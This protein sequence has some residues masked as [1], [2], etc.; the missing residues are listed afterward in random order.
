MPALP[1]APG[2]IMN[3]IEVERLTASHPI[4]HKKTEHKARPVVVERV[5][6]SQNRY[7]RNIYQ[8]PPALSNPYNPPPETCSLVPIS[9]KNRTIPPSPQP[10]STL[11]HPKSPQYQ[12]P[13]GI[14][15]VFRKT[16]MM[17]CT[18]KWGTFSPNYRPFQ[19]N[20]ALFR[21]ISAYLA[22]I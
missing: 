15:P 6:L 17:E 7:R 12:L 5:A 4:A 9:T 14:N 11:K 8:T 2:Q 13:I 10:E 20:L 1:A 22:V 3:A 19:P 16:P 21:A 18:L